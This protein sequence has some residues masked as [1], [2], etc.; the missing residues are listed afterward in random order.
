MFVKIDD[1][2]RTG[3]MDKDGKRVGTINVNGFAQI[4]GE[5]K[6]VEIDDDTKRVISLRKELPQKKP[7]EKTVKKPIKKNT[8]KKGS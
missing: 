5:S 8:V 3:Y 6:Y 2:H 7:V 4:I 1:S